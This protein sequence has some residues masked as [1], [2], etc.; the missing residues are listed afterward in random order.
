MTGKLIQLNHFVATIPITKPFVKNYNQLFDTF[1]PPEAIEESLFI[2]FNH[3][4][5][6]DK[7]ANGTASNASRLHFLE[8][9]LKLHIRVS[10]EVAQKMKS[11]TGREFY[12]VGLGA[13]IARD[14]IELHEACEEAVNLED[15]L[16][17]ILQSIMP[18]EFGIMWDGE[19][20]QL[21]HLIIELS[22]HTALAKDMALQAAQ[23]IT[24]QNIPSNDLLKPTAHV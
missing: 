2:L 23:L 13:D 19:K 7:M 10:Y 21:E 17:K 3:M 6:F 5:G 15:S 4:L 12:F 16:Q 14:L 18:N 24:N 11:S 9:Q 1:G 8:R 20:Q 22:R